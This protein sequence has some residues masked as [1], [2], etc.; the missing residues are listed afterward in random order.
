MI[1]DRGT[2]ILLS[3]LGDGYQLSC[4]KHLACSHQSLLLDLSQSPL[5]EKKTAHGYNACS[6][7]L[8]S[9]TF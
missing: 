2:Q 1:Y 5:E 6:N 4:I 8:T 7:R 9:E 3:V